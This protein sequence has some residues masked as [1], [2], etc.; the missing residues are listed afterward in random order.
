MTIVS[1]PFGTALFIFFPCDASVMNPVPYCTRKQK[2]P[3][4]GPKLKTHI[5]MTG[6]TDMILTTGTI[7]IEKEK[8]DDKNE[9][10]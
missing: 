4:D 5:L 1:S 6:T 9:W 10:S 2:R 8:E 3:R 7:V